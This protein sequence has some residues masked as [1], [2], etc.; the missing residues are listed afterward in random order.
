MTTLTH[1]VA[2]SATM[3]RRDLRH[4]ARG[5]ARAGATTGPSGDRLFEAAVP[6]PDPGGQCPRRQGLSVTRTGGNDGLEVHTDIEPDPIGSRL[7]VAHHRCPRK[8]GQ[9][10]RLGLAVEAYSQ[11]SVCGCDRI[12][13]QP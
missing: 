9:Q 7:A 3:L 6:L 5:R 12:G 2:D 8:R 4:A 13:E 10:V 1:A 11:A